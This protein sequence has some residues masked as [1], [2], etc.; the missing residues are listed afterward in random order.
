M[1]SENAQGF[2]WA[3]SKYYAAKR[4][5]RVSVKSDCSQRT[6]RVLAKNRATACFYIVETQFRA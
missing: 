1:L 4:A 3:F 5:I 6:K 2:P